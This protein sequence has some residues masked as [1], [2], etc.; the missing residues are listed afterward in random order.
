VQ[1]FLFKIVEVSK[2]TKNHIMKL[3]KNL[4]PVVLPVIAFLFFNCSG[5]AQTQTTSE[6]KIK[7]EFHCNGGKTKIE[8]ELAKLDGVTSVVA[9]LETKIVTIV[10]DPTKQSKET[11]VAAIEQTGHMTEFSKTEAK[12]SCTNHGK[13]GKNC[14]TPVE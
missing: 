10:F 5:N 3:L 4:L 12:S 1:V 14:D 13:D 6:V 9:D 7:T 2:P 8:T 11:L